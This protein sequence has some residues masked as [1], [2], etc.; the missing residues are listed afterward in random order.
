[1][2]K[3]YKILFVT[4]LT[5]IILYVA[6]MLLTRDSTFD[7][8]VLEQLDI[9]QIE[10]IEIIRAS[11]EKTINIT[12]T[13]M[14]NQIMQHFNDQPLRKVRFSNSD[15]EEAY[16]LTLHVNDERAIGMRLDDAKHLYIFLYEE[17]YMKDYK[18]LEDI[19]LTFIEALF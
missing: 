12:D 13:A 5:L 9:K 11:D 8:E 14:I 6:T 19:D 15:F 4:L 18:L 7:K 1:M 10:E 3:R 2:K 16:W 17:N